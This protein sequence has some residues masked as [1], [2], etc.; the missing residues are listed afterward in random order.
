MQNLLD[1]LDREGTLLIWADRM[2]RA[3]C[4][5]LVQAAKDQNDQTVAWDT[6]M[7]PLEVPGMPGAVSPAWRFRVQD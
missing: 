2:T 6:V 1:K 3:E 4:K 5:R 7:V